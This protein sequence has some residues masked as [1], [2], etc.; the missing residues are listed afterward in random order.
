M[1]TNTHFRTHI[2]RNLLNTSILEQNMFQTELIEKQWYSSCRSTYFPLSFTVFEIIKQQE[3]TLRIE[4]STNHCLLTSN[5]E[6]TYGPN[7]ASKAGL[8]CFFFCHG[9][10]ITLQATCPIK[11]EQFKEMF[12]LVSQRMLVHDRAMAVF[13]PNVLQAGHSLLSAGTVKSAEN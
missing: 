2:K 12:V 8:L 13:V 1:K 9:S 4:C 3:R 7:Q 6:W 5:L 11:F 10:V